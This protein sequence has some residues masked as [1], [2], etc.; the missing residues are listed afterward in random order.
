MS[1]KFYKIRNKEGLW[2]SGGCSLYSFGKKGK[3]WTSKGALA[4][5]LAMY[6]IDTA[7]K[8][9]QDWEIVEFETKETNISY[10]SLV[11]E[12]KK[13][14]NRLIEKYGTL[15]SEIYDS[16]EKESKVE[17]YRWLLVVE[18]PKSN[19]LMA[20]SIAQG[21][22]EIVSSLIKSSGIKRTDFKSKYTSYYYSLHF[23]V[24]FAFKEREK[25]MLFK[26]SCQHPATFLDLVEVAEIEEVEEITYHIV[27]N[28]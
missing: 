13:K 18:I 22:K 11:F 1:E 14:L 8:D 27:E 3:V 24:A 17:E 4:N 12:K 26:L 9:V 20:T 23:K 28:R 10:V 25:A 21:N 15:V 2:H 16:L 7:I 5:H 19:G 6:N